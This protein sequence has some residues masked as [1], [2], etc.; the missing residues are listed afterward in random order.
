MLSAIIL[1]RSREAY[2]GLFFMSILGAVIYKKKLLFFPLMAIVL[3]VVVN[4]FSQSNIVKHNAILNRLVIANEQLVSSE[5][6]FTIWPATINQIIKRPIL[7]YG[8]EVF[9]ESF[10]KFTPAKLL[11]IEA[12]R[13]VADRAHNEILDIASS[14][15]LLG[16]VAY[17]LFLWQ[18][19]Y[20]CIKKLKDPTAA[21]CLAS[22]TG[23]FVSNMF[24]FSATSNYILWW[25][26]AGIIMAISGKKTSLTIRIR[27]NNFCKKT[28]YLLLLIAIS[29]AIFFGGI[30]PLVADQAFSKANM[31]SSSLLHFYAIEE[32][33]NAS[34]NNPTEAYYPLRAADYAIIAAK[35][36]S[37]QYYRNILIIQAEWFLNR[38]SKL[39]GEDYSGILYLKAK[40]Y[41][42]LNDESLATKFFELAYEKT[43]KNPDLLIAWASSLSAQGKYNEAMGVYEKFLVLAPYWD[44]AFEIENSSAAEKRQ[45]R[46][47]FKHNVDFPSI[48]N[49]IAETEKWRGN[50][51]SAKKYQNYSQKIK[52]VMKNLTNRPS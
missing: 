20:L 42:V 24:G 43:P 27:M 2:L 18:L 7:G 12:F 23:L 37:D 6:R 41:S 11:E 33:K 39:L 9:S 13:S 49:K 1:T 16:L 19:I 14:I 5:P 21:A 4:V 44:Q 31:Y 29:L 40:F 25:L 10:A 8:Q 45:F 46:L 51:D 30:R 34:I 22:L 26:I 32:F 38:A 28:I 48:F 15:G 52:E 3:L 47:F 36:T 35:N 50:L 17:L